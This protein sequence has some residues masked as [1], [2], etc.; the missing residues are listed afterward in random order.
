ML[1]LTILAVLLNTSHAMF[2]CFGC[3]GKQQT[4]P[5][6]R[7]PLHDRLRLIIPPRSPQRALGITNVDKNSTKEKTFDDIKQIP[8]PQQV[9]KNPLTVP[10]VKRA[11]EV[12]RRDIHTIAQALFVAIGKSY[13]A[14]IIDTKINL[15]AA[16]PLFKSSFDFGMYYIN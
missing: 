5:R 16:D 14:V 4:E 2:N 12:K 3:F 10:E 6:Q 8:Q 11:P 9:R 15:V 1:S 7:T 13:W